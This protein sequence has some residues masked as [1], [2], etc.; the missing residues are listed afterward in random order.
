MEVL[1]ETE[2][3]RAKIRLKLQWR[4]YRGKI[5]D[6]ELKQAVEMLDELYP[7]EPSLSFVLLLGARPPRPLISRVPYL[8][9]SKLKEAAAIA[10][11][12]GLLIGSTIAFGILGFLG[13][14]VI[15]CGGAALM[16]RIARR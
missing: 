4:N 15:V 10:G 6:A 1:H 7:L 16:G 3:L 9:R 11:L 8:N 2:T 14:V 13:Y 12:I 5:S